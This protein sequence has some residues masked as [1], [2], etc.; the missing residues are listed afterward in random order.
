VSYVSGAGVELAASESGSGVPVVV[1]H[2]MG[3]V[4]S[5]AGLPGR[6]VLYDRRGY[7]DSEAPEPYTRT[8]VGEQAEDLACV[9]RGSG[10]APAVL[11]G[12][13]LGALAVLDV[14]LRH[15]E[16]ARGAVLVDPPAYMFVAEATEAL[17]S[18]RAALEDAIRSGGPEG[19]MAWWLSVRGRSASG[20]S[21]VR[22][23]IAFFA[24]YGALATL[25]LTH[26][27]LLGIRVPVAVV[28][29]DGA[30]AHDVLAADAL[31]DTLAEGRAEGS[32][33]EAVSAIAR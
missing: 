26:G 25:S 30:R 28:T 12:H 2:G 11:V 5:A 17:S 1:V 19:A 9:V 20:R 22:D 33:A 4:P 29:S 8:T 3:A 23:A 27:G 6:V 18:E 31:L 32:V 16:L 13:D 14:L 15:A 10:A 7:G 21:G 24:D